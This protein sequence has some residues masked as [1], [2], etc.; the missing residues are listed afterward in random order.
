MARKAGIPVVSTFHVQA[1]HLLH[2]VGLRSPTLVDWTYQV[3]PRHHLRPVRRGPVPERLRRTGTAALR[4]VKR[5]HRG[6]LQRRPPEY[7][8]LPRGECERFE[9][10]FT[11]L[12]VGRL[13]KEKRHDLLIEAIAAPATRSPSG[14]SSSATD[15]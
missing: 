2:N 12:S 13:A 8:P 4:A 9:G 3:L 1:E 15:R 10:R 7:Q 6:D 14:S 11:I 5:P